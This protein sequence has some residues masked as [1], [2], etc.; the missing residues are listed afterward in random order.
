MKKCNG[1]ITFKLCAVKQADHL[2]KGKESKAKENACLTITNKARQ[3]NAFYAESFI[4]ALV[5]L[6]VTPCI[7]I[8][9]T[10]LLNLP[11]L[12]LTTF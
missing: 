6:N 3:V 1:H 10:P 5:M 4:S 9:S 8:W 11:H 12:S 2:Y 7:N